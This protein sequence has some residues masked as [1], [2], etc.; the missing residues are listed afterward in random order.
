MPHRG[1]KWPGLHLLAGVLDDAGSAIAR[2]GLWVLVAGP[3]LASLAK[4]SVWKSGSPQ[5]LRGHL[6]HMERSQ[7][8]MFLRGVKAPGQERLWLRGRPGG[9]LDT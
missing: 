6:R 9:Q 3:Q 7:E 2:D 8:D 5:L 1:F 4:A